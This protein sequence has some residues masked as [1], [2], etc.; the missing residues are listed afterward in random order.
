MWDRVKICF[1]ALG[2]QPENK[3]VFNDEP[4]VLHGTEQPGKHFSTLL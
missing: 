2:A 3:E 4:K 1:A